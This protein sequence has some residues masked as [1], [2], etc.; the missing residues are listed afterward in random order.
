MSAGE[1][2]GARPHDHARHVGGEDEREHGH[3]HRHE[4]GPQ[5]TVYALRTD[6]GVAA[7]LT[8]DALGEALSAFVRA[9]VAGLERHGC[10]LIGHV[11]GAFVPP[12]SGAL[13]AGPGAAAGR[14]GFAFN[15]TSF[16]GGVALRGAWPGGVTAQLTVNAI[17]YGVAADVVE[18]ETLDALA[19]LRARISSP[20][21]PE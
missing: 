21:A 5:P 6:I 20:E 19:E 9:L 7:G 4:D 14:G 1:R 2:H 8:D 15:V 11:K 16:K 3:A 13:S 18:S 12:A 10:R 17:V